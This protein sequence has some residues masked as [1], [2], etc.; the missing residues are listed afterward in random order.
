MSEVTTTNTPA[1]PAPASGLSA[2][3]PSTITVV[4]A[5]I[6]FF[7][8]FLDIKCNTMSVQTVSGFQM[9]TGFQLNN[10]SSNNSLLNDFKTPGIDNEITKSTTNTGKRDP[11]MYALAALILGVL[12]L[13]ISF[14]KARSASTGVIITAVLAAASLIGLWIDVK[15]Q[16]KSDVLGLGQQ[17]QDVVISIE[18]T[19]WF[20]LSVVAFL[21]SAYFG[22]RKLKAK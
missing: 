15:K 6:L 14:V 18:F 17:S 13:G 11:N 1:T 20:Y 4:I 5:V 21:L 9:A 2:I 7:M 3:S 12:A 16:V 8:P 22:F 10:Q 19:P